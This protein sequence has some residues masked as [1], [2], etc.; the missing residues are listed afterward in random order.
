MSKE[1]T[2]KFSMRLNHA[3]DASNF[4]AL[5]KGRATALAELLGSSKK[6]A[7]LWLD[8]TALPRIETVGIIAEKLNVNF[9]WLAT[10]AGAIN[11]RT[12][13]NEQE[14]L[15]WKKI[16]L[17][18]WGRAASI[19]ERPIQLK[20]ATDLINSDTPCSALSYALKMQDDSMIPGIC[21]GD[22]LVIDPEC[23]PSPNSI[24]IVKWVE[25]NQITCAQYL[26]YG[27][28]KI[29]RPNNPAYPSRTLSHDM[30]EVIFLG[31]VRQAFRIYD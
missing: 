12:V 24:M 11:E 25:S 10:G 15:A 3:L 21:P 1:L 6:G 8:G 17:V 7:T 19:I 16:P 4:P 9:K 13:Y 26:I 29:L 31:K 2:I 23:S 5:G 18:S 14:S 30:S 22:I 20:E 28:D 27:N